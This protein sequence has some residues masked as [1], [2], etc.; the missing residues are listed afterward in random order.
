MTK[1]RKQRTFA[2]V[3]FSIL[4][5]KARRAAVTFLARRL[6]RNRAISF[7]ADVES[8]RKLVFILPEEPLAALHQVENV[9]SLLVLFNDSQVTLLCE[10]NVPA[11]FKS[12]HGV[13]AIE[14]YDG[15]DRFLFSREAHRI[16][17]LLAAGE[18]DV[19]FLLE[20]TPDLSLLYC[21]AASCAPVRIGFDEAGAYPFLNLRIRQQTGLRHH[22]DRNLLMCKALGGKPVKSVRWVIPKDITQEIEHLMQEAG[23]PRKQTIAGIDAVSLWTLCGREW[24]AALMED[25][26]KLGKRTWYF[27]GDGT[28]DGECHTWLRTTKHPAFWGLSS[29]RAAALINRSDLII[30]AQSL[31]FEM[32]FLLGTRSIGLFDEEKLVQYCRNTPLSQGIVYS[33][34]PDESL[35]R[36]L[37][38]IVAA[39]P[40]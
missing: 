30:S 6:V 9:M 14:T 16:A 18:F 26:D 34:R 15:A 21:A 39:L 40:S 1:A 23:I 3:L 7:P 12:I 24:I 33:G 32:A 19:C 27:F 11:F 28:P 2:S 22:A 13:A 31:L 38:G 20:R 10:K 37:V 8:A 36:Y 25:L 17:A 35:R 5:K 29:S 4:G